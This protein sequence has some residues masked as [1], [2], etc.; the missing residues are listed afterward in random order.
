MNY[1]TLKLSP[2]LMM[3][4]M[5]ATIYPWIRQRAQQRFLDEGDD[6]SGKWAPLL[7]STNEFRRSGGFGE[8]HPINRR[9]GELESY[10]TGSD[11]MIAPTPAGVMMRYPGTE[12]SGALLEK[13]QTAQRGRSKPSTVP[14]PVLSLGIADMNFTL[15]SLALYIQG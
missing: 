13:V 15:S 3:G 6:A 1:L 14:R 4:F 5:S 10:I 11:A 2:A 8:A 9:T 7:E 12:P